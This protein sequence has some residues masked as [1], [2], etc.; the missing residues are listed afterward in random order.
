MT[1]IVSPRFYYEAICQT[2]QN[3]Q[4]WMVFDGVE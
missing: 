2:L 1:S 4:I 3:I